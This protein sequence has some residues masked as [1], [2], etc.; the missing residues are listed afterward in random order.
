LANNKG[1]INGDMADAK[2]HKNT[3]TIIFHN[4]VSKSFLPDPLFIN[5]IFNVEL[6]VSEKA[7]GE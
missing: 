4:S 2:K 7:D 5:L 3:S 6:P 1:N